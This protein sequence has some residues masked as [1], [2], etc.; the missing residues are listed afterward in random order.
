MEPYRS[1]YPN[2]GL[3]LPNTKRVA[4]RVVVL[5]SGST[6]SEDHIR[7]IVAILKLL[8]E[9]KPEFVKRSDPAPERHA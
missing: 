9:A 6:I 5:P 2:A 3:V 4:E 1:Y 7:A 8:G